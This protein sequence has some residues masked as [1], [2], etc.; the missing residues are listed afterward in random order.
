MKTNSI[1]NKSLSDCCGCGSC[2]DVCPKEAISMVADDEG[3]LYPQVSQD[4][5][6]NCG[7]CTK[8]VQQN[9]IISHKIITY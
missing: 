6:I 5:C 1:I 7:L 2:R 4:K 3:F 8:N 9:R